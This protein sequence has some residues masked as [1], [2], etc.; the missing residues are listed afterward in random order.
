VVRDGKLVFAK[1][2]GEADLQKQKSNSPTTAFYLASLSKQFT[3]MAVVLLAQDGKLRLDDD[4]RK[5][6]PEV[7]KLGHITLLE[8]LQHTS[9]LRDYYTLLGIAGWQ[10]NEL[11]TE[12]GLLELVSR[13]EALNFEPDAEF[14]Y[15]NTGYALLAIVVR[16]AS[17]KSLRDFAAARIFAPLGMTETQ[18]RDDHSMVVQSEAIGYRPQGSGYVVS[19]PQL[20]VV[21]DGG[22]FSTVADLAKWDANF[23]SGVVGG[24]SGVALLQTPGEL[25]DGRGTG[26]G[27]GLVIGTSDG[28]RTVS[29]SG[30]FGGYSSTYLRYPDKKL[31]VIALC[32]ISTAASQLAQEVANLYIPRANHRDI[33]RAAIEG[34]QGNVTPA[35]RPQ[36]GP[37]VFTGIQQPDEQVWLEGRYYSPEL[38]MEV[39][40]RSQDAELIMARPTGEDLRFIRRAHDLFA[41]NDDIT[42]QIERDPWGVV[43]GLLLSAGRVRKLE[44]TKRTGIVGLAGD[45]NGGS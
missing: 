45:L 33:G 2:Y 24:K 35:P 41:S 13:Q 14:L 8:M 32:N 29:H 39:R 43:S 4:I 1:G 5:W 26:Y 31:S 36:A 10:S 20:D 11:F 17:G 9:G 22:V 44:F 37:R 18:F 25:R 21:G 38:G 28:L 6:V 15:S 3:A 23:D 30:S 27:L 42:L 34:L 7:P 12:R 16:R 19:I 40:I